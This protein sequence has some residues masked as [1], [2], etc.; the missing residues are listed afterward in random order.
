MSKIQMTVPIVEMDGDEMTRILWKTIKESGY[1]DKLRNGI[2]LTGGCANLTG[3]A[4][5]I[6]ELSGFN[7][8]IGY[9][10]SKFISA[11]G[12]PGLSETSAAAS[13][14]MLLLAKEDR[15]LN[16]TT[17]PELK[18]EPQPEPEEV[19]TEAEN[20]TSPETGAD[21]GAMNGT[22]SGSETVAAQELQGTLFPEMPD[23]KDTAKKEERG[24]K[25]RKGFRIYW[26][27]KVIDTIGNLFESIE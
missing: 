20:V 1:S 22:E 4:N 21:V 5:F 23:E 19:R 16:C 11:S 24:K 9:P 2:V 18:T 26:G 6:R 8:R 15:H 10:R 14:G 13:V 12:F 7:V 17:E 27:H 25:E 3:C